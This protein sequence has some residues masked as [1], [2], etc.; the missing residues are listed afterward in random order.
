MTNTTLN[1]PAPHDRALRDGSWRA[2]GHHDQKYAD[3]QMH[4]VVHRV[5]VKPDQR[6]ACVLHDVAKPVTKNPTIPIVTYSS[7]ND[8]APR[9][10]TGRRA[11]RMLDSNAS[12]AAAHRA[13][14]HP[15]EGEH[16][17]NDEQEDDPLHCRLVRAHAGRGSHDDA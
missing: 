14:G 5:D 3:Q 12:R 1:R 17:R 11:A 6:V 7:P 15:G 4:E 13:A 16:H 10:S 9:R 2:G 8:G